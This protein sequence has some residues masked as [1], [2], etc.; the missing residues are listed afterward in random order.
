MPIYTNNEKARELYM[1]GSRIKAAW[2]DGVQVFTAK[3]QLTGLEVYA[4]SGFYDAQN[5]LRGMLEEYG[6]NYRTVKE[7]PFK[8]DS[9]KAI[10]FENMFSG[11]AN[12]RSVPDLDTSNGVS[13]TNMFSGCVSLRSVPDLDTSKGV[14]FMDMFRTCIGL[15]DGNVRLI[16]KDGKLPSLRTNMITVSGL[17]REPFYDR[18]GHPIN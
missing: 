7:I 9:S 15:T 13:F 3:R 6:E 11:C 1:H 12:L 14:T 10:S 5:W 18:N 17:T 8:I 16:R 2:V 4:G